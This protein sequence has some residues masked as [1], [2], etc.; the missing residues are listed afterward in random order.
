MKQIL[1]CVMGVSLFSCTP[2]TDDPTMKERMYL[3]ASKEVTEEIHKKE[4]IV[5]WE[6]PIPVAN[7]EGTKKDWS[8]KEEQLDV[9]IIDS[10][11]KLTPLRGTP[12]MIRSLK[13]LSLNQEDEFELSFTAITKKASFLIG[14][15]E[16][17]YLVVQFANEIM[18]SDRSKKNVYRYAHG[19]YSAN[20]Q[21]DHIKIVGKPSRTL[22]YVNGEL[23]GVSQPI[24]LDW[25]SIKVS[26]VILMS[27][28]NV[29]IRK[30]RQ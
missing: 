23:E 11:W 2:N 17:D 29:R 13:D 14:D 19:H 7:L 10:G 4:T 12:D 16:S 6:V 3:L 28:I 15:L 22:V 26:S 20:G 1:L 25:F 9:R 30:I 18:V 8:Y 24:K 27:N 21:I 5:E